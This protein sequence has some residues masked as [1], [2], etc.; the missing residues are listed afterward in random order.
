M[1]QT[2]TDDWS[3]GGYSNAKLPN[4]M[5]SLCHPTIAS[6][7]FA[8]VKQPDSTRGN[9][10]C[11]DAMTAKLLATLGNLAGLVLL[12]FGAPGLLLSLELEPPNVLAGLADT[13]AGSQQGAVC[14]ALGSLGAH[15]TLA[16]LDNA[17]IDLGERAI[18]EG[19][20]ENAAAVAAGRARVGR[21][22]VPG[23]VR[24]RGRR[25][26]APEQTMA[27]LLYGLG[28]G[29]RLVYGLLVAASKEAVPLATLFVDGLRS[30]LLHWLRVTRE[31]RHDVLWDF[32][33]LSCGE[34]FGEGGLN[35]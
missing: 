26:T 2:K 14:V 32:Y 12:D 21:Y 20:V 29:G 33:V 13:L 30:R 18:A 17:G 34:M 27:L 11:L 7:I 16:G 9:G 4:S 5:L 24:G 6:G 31:E 19:A 22:G 25:R 1:V 10:G 35:Y 28:D 15:D 8:Q 23:Y 3:S